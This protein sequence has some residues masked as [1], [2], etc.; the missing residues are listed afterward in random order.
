MCSQ[1][2]R[3]C[4]NHNTKRITHLLLLVILIIPGFVLGQ[5]NPITLTP[6]DGTVGATTNHVYNFTSSNPIP[7]DG[8]IEFTYP[9]GF[10]FGSL[11]SVTSLT[12]DGTFSIGTAGS[13]VTITRNGDG[14]A[15][16]AGALDITL[17]SVT[18]ITTTGS[19]SVTVET[20]DN[21]G[22]LIDTGTPSYTFTP[23]TLASFTLTGEPLT[24]QAGQPF[25]SPG[26]D[27]TITA[28]DT[29]NNVKTDY[30]GSVYFTST[31]AQ[32]QLTYHSGN[33][34]TFLITE[35]GV[36][37]FSGNDF[38]LRT[39]PLPTTTQSITV[40]DGIISRVSNNITVTPAALA[41]FDFSGEPANI[42]AGQPFSSTI[43]ITARDTYNNVKTDYT[44]QVYF[45][46]TDPQAVLPYTSG[47][48]YT[49]TGGDAGIHNFA[50]SGFEL[51]TTG[52]PTITVTD[53]SISQPGSAITVD[54]GPLASFTLTGEPA[55]VEAGVPFPTP[56]NDIVVTAYD[57]YNNIKTDYTGSVY[58]AS[59]DAQAVLPYTI[60]SQ[61]TFT[62]GDAGVQSFTGSSFELRTT[63]SRTI[64]VTNAVISRTS[65]A[66]TVTP[67]DLARFTIAGEPASVVA[68]VPFATP[69][70]DI[71]VTAYDTYN[72]I[73]TDYSGIV[74]WSST[75]LAPF[76]ATLP[77]DDGNGWSGGSKTFVGSTFILYNTPSHQLQISGGGYSQS[78]SWITV[79]P[80]SLASIIIRDASGN[81][82]NPMDEFPM[83]VGQTLVLY[84]AGYD[85]YTN[86]ISDVGTDWSSTGSLSPAISGSSVSSYSFIPNAPGSG[87]IRAEDP[88]FSTIYDNTGLITVNAGTVTHFDIDPLGDQIVDEPFTLTITALDAS[89]IV[90]TGFTGTVNMYDQTGTL[91]RSVSGNFVNGVW[92][93]GV[94]IRDVA[95]NDFITVYQTG[96]PTVN[97][98]SNNFDVI[99][100]PGID[101]LDFKAV[102]DDQVTP[103]QAVTTD[104]TLDWHLIMNLENLGSAGVHL[105]SVRL[106]FFVNGDLRSDYSVIEPTLFWSSGD[107]SLRGGEIDSLLI[108][109]N[110]TGHDSGPATVQGY[111]YLTSS[112]GSFLSLD[113]FTSL[114]VQTPAQLSINE[115]RASQEEVTVGQDSTWNVSVILT[116][117][118]ES[119]V[120]VN[121]NAVNTYISFSP[122]SPGWQIVRPAD[123]GGGTGWI[124]WGNTTDSLVFQIQR[125]GFSSGSHSIHAFVRGTEINTNRA[126]IENTLGGGWEIITVEDSAALRILEVVNI[127]PNSPSVTVNQDFSIRITVENTG[128]DGT[129]DVAVQLVTDGSSDFTQAIP[130]VIPNIPGGESRSVELAGQASSSVNPSEIFTASAL[131]LSDNLGDSL[132]SA[133]SVDD[134]TLAVVQDPP[135]LN[136]GILAPSET[137]IMGGRIDPWIL[138]VP[139]QNNGDAPILFDPPQASD[140]IFS[141]DDIIQT[142]YLV[143]P[144]TNLMGGGLTLI[145]GDQDILEYTITNTG[146]LGGVVDILGRIRGTD[147]NA[148]IALSDSNV[149]TILVQASPAFRII[150]TRVKAYNSDA[151]G[152]GIVNKGQAFQVVVYVEN[153]LTGTVEN[154]QVRLTSN[155][156]TVPVPIYGII[157]EITPTLRDSVVFNVTAASPAGMSTNET[158]TANITEA[159][160]QSTQSP[161]PIGPAIDNNATVTIEEPASLR[162]QLELSN[163]DGIFS[164]DQEFTLDVYL[165]NNGQGEV[166]NSGWVELLLPSGRGYT[167]APGQ[168]DRVQIGPNS[169]VQWTITSPAI[170]ASSADSIYVILEPPSL[171]INTGQLAAVENR[172]SSVGSYI[173]GRELD[174]DLSISNPS[175]ARD[176][177]V[178]SYQSFVV[179]ALVHHQNMK[180]I[181]AE[182]ALPYGYKTDDNVKK[183]VIEDS[184]LWQVNA[185]DFAIGQNFILVTTEG[186]DSLTDVSII[187]NN[188]YPDTLE[189]VTVERADLSLNLSTLD[190]SVSLGQVF[191]VNAYVE[192]IGTADVY[193]PVGVTLDPLPAGYTTSDPYTQFFTTD[194]VSWLIKAPSQPTQE[195]VNIEASLTSVPLDENTNTEA[196][197][198]R[199]S[200]K[201]AVTTVGTWLSLSQYPRP[202]TLAGLIEPGQIGVWLAAFELTNRGELGANGIEIYSTSFYVE[203]TGGT[204]IDPNR[205]FSRIRIAP[206]TPLGSSMILDTV[207]VYGQISQLQGT[208]QPTNPMNIFFN[209]RDLV[210]PARDTA[211]IAIL[212][213]ISNDVE[214]T[215]FRLNLSHGSLI[216]ARD[217]F[218]PQIVVSVLDPLG[219][220]IVDLGLYEN[221]I[222]P[223]EYTEPGSEPYLLNCP[224][225]FGEPG[226][227][228]TNIIYYLK[229]DTNVRFRIFT[230]TGQLVWSRSYTQSD[231]QGKEGY[232]R[233]GWDSVVWDGKN[234]VGQRVV[235]GVY[236]LFM[237]TDYGDTAKTKIAVV[238]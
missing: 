27:I 176:Q 43:D 57:P 210:I 128:E 86:Y 95:V 88:T 135:V 146:W 141:I 221:Q 153:G 220:E 9:V 173:I 108:T 96:A 186:K 104:Q 123:L 129:H 80:S 143:V 33:Q 70:N 232:H 201:V 24:I 116:N 209:M 159:T 230:I 10:T 217:E 205:I 175:G 103:L 138:R 163:P 206:M 99:A 87:T 165:Q 102:R 66:I 140:I 29:W 149:G 5:L 84:S 15:T 172:T 233:I 145:G 222:L 124:L 192:N 137:V 46:S 228:E 68:G 152:N 41:S 110:T 114:S 155:G 166:D 39:I 22:I 174:A 203:D 91:S 8:I 31:D 212:G 238:K 195:A 55:S 109:V 200:D 115:V 1:I 16:G 81:G 23:G 47:S 101:F 130:P 204:S 71:I 76:T 40:T 180:D 56:G 181:T 160:L 45:T 191:S 98:I 154:I 235:N 122:S 7:A 236:I 25:L 61:Y 105:D 196:F 54:P 6:A 131:G 65:T 169:D 197:V 127:A 18:N 118:G 183:G 49:F 53:G 218:S 72:N 190:N 82:G 198:S 158:F 44:G 133:N 219:D 58:F 170:P 83:V 187:G 171:E 215:D 48:R 2:N 120:Q 231:P 227:E 237:K 17:S 111:V 157:A 224:N 194:V 92:S 3:P 73:K 13:V 85:L 121:S 19:H 50:G 144:P 30:I 188:G 211:Y 168:N 26:N 132:Q 32:A 63:P 189:V 94:T 234:D 156:Q 179:K 34:Y 134:T 4:R 42:D 119:A 74:L 151:S 93:G 52:T 148:G 226:K 77:L 117:A 213:D 37:T 147:K 36:H 208:I 207:L 78:S 14:T 202:D 139:V 11:S 161:A 184:V 142:D 89:D 106:Y 136:V 107:D 223:K 51:R 67:T 164:V 150:A 113:T 167:L 216:D 185:P 60:G 199:R 20:Q 90:A 62:L 100:A 182:I 21:L 59:D 225:P 229:E 97:G 35:N 214:I 12:I 125:T 28:Y 162:L 112:N 126:L 177:V 75:D 38:E 69:G 178:S 64:T 79:T 193:G